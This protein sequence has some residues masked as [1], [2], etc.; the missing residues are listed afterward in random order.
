M[1][2]ALYDLTYG[3]E[4][5]FD[6]GTVLLIWSILF[7]CMLILMLIKRNAKVPT[8][9]NDESEGLKLRTKPVVK[10]N[11]LRS[12]SGRRMYRMTMPEGLLG[13]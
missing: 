13:K 1:K 6:I 10:D 8:P 11:I 12:L 7:V 4:M 2:E 9:V 5:Y 3:L